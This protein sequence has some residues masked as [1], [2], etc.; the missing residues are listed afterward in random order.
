[1]EQA[2]VQLKAMGYKVG[3]VT[4]NCS[5]AVEI[6]LKGS[7]LPHDLLLTRD[8]VPAAKPHPVH[9]EAALEKMG[10]TA[11]RTI[12]VGD[13]SI[14]IVA[15]LAVGIPFNIGVLTGRYSSRQLEEAGAC[16]VLNC[17]AELPALLGRY[18]PSPD[19]RPS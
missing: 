14:D 1:M 9:L 3:I 15:G 10:S 5:Q 4:R 11:E 18:R 2:L 16:R 7:E 17:A 12:L 8:H 6:I 19:S 13:S